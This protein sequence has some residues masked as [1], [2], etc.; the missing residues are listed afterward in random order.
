MNEMEKEK[1][2]HSFNRSFRRSELGSCVRHDVVAEH[3][4]HLI[5][6]V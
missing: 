4:F 3:I 5:V 2:K 6:S 1:K